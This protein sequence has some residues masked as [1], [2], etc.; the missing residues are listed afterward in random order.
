MWF[1]LLV[2]GDLVKLKGTFYVLMEDMGAKQDHVLL[3]ES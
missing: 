1:G 3:A 2:M